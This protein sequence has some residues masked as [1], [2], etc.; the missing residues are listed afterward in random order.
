M[1]TVTARVQPEI[2]QAG[3][4]LASIDG[5]ANAVVRQARPIGEVTITGPGVGPQLA[6]Q[7]VLS[8]IIAVARRQAENS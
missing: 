6:G 5:V 7:G 8:D 2:V 3:D 4:L 1:G